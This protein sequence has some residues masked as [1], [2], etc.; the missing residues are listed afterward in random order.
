MLRYPR[1]R[2]IDLGPFKKETP[3]GSRYGLPLQ[4]GFCRR[5]VISNQRPNSAVEYEH[6]RD[7]RKSTINFDRDGVCDACRLAEQ[8]HGTIDWR[9]REARLRDLCDRH[10]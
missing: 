7:S 8:K 9:E 3:E 5:C 1:H 10:R 2:E 4:V 6:T